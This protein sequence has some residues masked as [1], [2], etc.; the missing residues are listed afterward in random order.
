MNEIHNKIFVGPEQDYK[1]LS[2]NQSGWYV[3]HATKE[4]YH[5][6]A[7][8]YEGTNPSANHPEYLVA[9]RGNRMMLNLIDSP[10]EID[11]PKEI[12]DRALDFI[13]EGVANDH[14]ILIHC[15][16]GLSRSATIGLLYL[17]KHTTRI[18]SSNVGDAMR[19]YEEI[20]PPFN[21][22]KAMVCFLKKH[23]EKYFN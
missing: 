5:R 3:L 18:K 23:W 11:I 21:P 7:L 19:E 17:K 9:R 14:K 12:F 15:T 4:P 6:T 10:V 16:E 1:D 8:K 20:Y 22:G 13:S 2:P